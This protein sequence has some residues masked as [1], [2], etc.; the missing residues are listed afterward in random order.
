[1]IRDRVIAGILAVSMI[2]EI[3]T[4]FPMVLLFVHRLF[5]GSLRNAQSLRLCMPF[6]LRFSLF[7]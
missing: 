7:G 6:R 2:H 3:R 5:A 4:D 1:M